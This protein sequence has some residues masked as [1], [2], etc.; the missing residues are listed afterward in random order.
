MS[1]LS[2]SLET[3]EKLTKLQKR[4]M[5]DDI[6]EV[7]STKSIKGLNLYWKYYDIQCISLK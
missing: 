7:A 2:L 1:S 5:Q 3:S 6:Y 4:F